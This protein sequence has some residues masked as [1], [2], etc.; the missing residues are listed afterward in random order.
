MVQILEATPKSIQVVV[1]C[2]KSGGVVILPTSTNYN[3][4]CN[5]FDEAAVKRLFEAKKTD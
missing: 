1:D 3:I 2:L 4:L 5:P